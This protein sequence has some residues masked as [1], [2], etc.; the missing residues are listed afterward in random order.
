MAEALGRLRMIDGRTMVGQWALPG[1]SSELAEALGGQLD[2][3]DA[4]PV[5]NVVLTRG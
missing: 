5:V 4:T 2:T 1:L 3:R